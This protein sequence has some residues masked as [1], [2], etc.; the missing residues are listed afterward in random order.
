MGRH[1]VAGVGDGLGE[2]R[3]DAVG[4]VVS[5]WCGDRED[6]RAGG[7]GGA[8]RHR[9]LGGGQR[10][11]VIGIVG[12]DH[13]GAAGCGPGDAEGEVIRLGPGAG[14][15]HM[16]QLGREEGEEALGIGE[17]AVVEVAG[18]GGQRGSLL[19]QC[20]DHAGVAMAD[21]GDVVVA[22]K[23]GVPLRVV[24]VDALSPDKV[25]RGFIEQPVGGPKRAGTAVGEGRV[26]W[27][28]VPGPGGVGVQHGGLARHGI[29]LSSGCSRAA[30]S[31]A[32]S[33]PARAARPARDTGAL[34]RM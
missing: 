13:P 19:G 23:V 14:E 22:V 12:D 9:H 30:A 34:R 6:G 24:E 7:D 1:A 2:A 4:V 15:H 17:D 11:A 29:W 25:D 33:R 31:R 16:L 10:D 26:F 3:S 27:R 8:D 32:G 21:R 5:A 20:P 28:Q 18:V